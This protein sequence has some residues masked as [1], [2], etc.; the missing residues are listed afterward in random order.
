MGDI[1]VPYKNL[2]IVTSSQNKFNKSSH[3][4]WTQCAQLFVRT[5]DLHT[6]VEEHMINLLMLRNT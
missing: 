5:L 6:H 1:V 3:S 2:V 4:I